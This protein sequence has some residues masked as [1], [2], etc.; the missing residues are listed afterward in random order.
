MK[1]SAVF[2]AVVGVAAGAIVL[3]GQ[4]ASA[5]TMYCSTP[6]LAIPDNTPAGVSNSQVINE[7][8]PPPLPPG[9]ICN[10]N[11]TVDSDQTN[12]VTGAP[13]CVDLVPVELMD[14]ESSL[15]K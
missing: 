15:G 3:A 8:D 5:Q 7:V 2:T 9:Q 4:V 11:Y 12:P 10:Q 6:N 13:V 14:F 1:R